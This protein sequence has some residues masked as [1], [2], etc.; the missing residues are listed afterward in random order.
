MNAGEDIFVD[1]GMQSHFD[2]GTLSVGASVRP[3]E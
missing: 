3:P 1:A 2:K